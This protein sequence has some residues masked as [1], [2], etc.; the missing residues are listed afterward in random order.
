MGAMGGTHD[1]AG[2]DVQ[3]ANLFAECETRSTLEKGN[4][5]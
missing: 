4:L 5:Q 2:A 1:V 3:D